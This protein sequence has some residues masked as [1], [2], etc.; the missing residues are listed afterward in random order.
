[1]KKIYYE[2][3]EYTNNQLK[4]MNYF[5]AEDILLSKKKAED[6]YKL[7]RLEAIKTNAST[8]KS[9]LVLVIM[10]DYETSRYVISE[11]NEKIQQLESMVLSSLTGIHVEIPRWEVREAELIKELD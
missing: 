1:M 4:N 9:D 2:V 3:L 10:D 6:Y 11:T 5:S 7:K 8:V